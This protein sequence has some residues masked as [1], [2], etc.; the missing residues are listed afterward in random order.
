MAVRKCEPMITRNG[1]DK[2][3]KVLNFFPTWNQAEKCKMEGERERALLHEASQTSHTQRL[4]N[5][6]PGDFHQSGTGR[7][8]LSPSNQNIHVAAS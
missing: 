8:I 5:L 1:W 7:K 3:K 4:T 6:C 2:E